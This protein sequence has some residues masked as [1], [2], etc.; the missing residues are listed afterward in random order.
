MADRKERKEDLRIRRTHKLLCDAMFSLLETRS[1]DDISVVDI[2]DRAMVHRA[3]FYK[4]FKDKYDFMEYV[5]KEKIREFYIASTQQEKFSDPIDIYHALI[6]NVIH[7]IEDNKQML[8]ISVQSS[9]NSFFDSIHKIIF[10]ELLDFL[11]AS[12]EKGVKF[13]VPTDIV[14]QFLTGGF[15]ALVRWWIADDI[16]Y[17]KEE[18]ASYI[19]MMLTASSAETNNCSKSENGSQNQ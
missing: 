2:C 18:M 12:R 11:N 7:F 17:T 8:K 14:A 1:F 3:T 13:D 19:E 10:E 6:K 5:T 16:S 9:T 15:I 4:H